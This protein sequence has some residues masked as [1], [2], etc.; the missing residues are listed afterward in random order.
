MKRKKKSKWILSEEKLPEVGQRVEVMD[1]HS[2]KGSGTVNCV[3]GEEKIFTL[4]RHPSGLENDLRMW[5]PMPPRKKTTRKVTT[6]KYYCD[7]T[8]EIVE[9]LPNTPIL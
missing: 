4:R 7:R 5:K 1:R 2:N 6:G 8:S 3:N 9:E